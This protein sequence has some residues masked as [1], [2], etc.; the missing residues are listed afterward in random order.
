[1]IALCF[2]ILYLHQF[3][4]RKD[5]KKKNNGRG[6]GRNGAK[7]PKLVVTSINSQRDNQ[8]VGEDRSESIDTNFVN[9]ILN[10]S[11]FE[12][13][14]LK[15]PKTRQGE[16]FLL[17]VSEEEYLEPRKSPKSSLTSTQK[18]SK[19]RDSLDSSNS[20]TSTNTKSFQT[21][22]NQLKTQFRD[23]LYYQLVKKKTE[24]NF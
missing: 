24:N 10:K 18:Q 4:Q 14:G 8:S 3:N 20:S 2:T 1:M 19:M 6:G 17:S 23:F 13:R 7:D 9:G 15:P 11:V 21:H 16:D 5:Q 12:V 22:N